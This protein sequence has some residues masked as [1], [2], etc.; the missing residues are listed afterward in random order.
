MESIALVL[1]EHYASRRPP[2]TLLL[3]TPVTGWIEHWLT[4]RRKGS[5]DIRVPQRGEL[6]KLRAM[7]D[8]NARIPC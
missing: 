3:P 1:S 2:R 6:A 7:A 4:E 5:V 8:S